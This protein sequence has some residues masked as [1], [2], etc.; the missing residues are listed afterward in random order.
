M[1]SR[2]ENRQKNKDQAHRLK[3]V[4]RDSIVMLEELKSSLIML[5]RTFD[6]L[7]KNKTGMAVES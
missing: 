4:L 7:N 1:V 5:Q 6:L 2:A 3:G